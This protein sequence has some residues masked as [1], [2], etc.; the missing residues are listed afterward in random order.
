MQIEAYK[1]DREVCL[2]M[3]GTQTYLD[4]SSE[5]GEYENEESNILNALGL[6]IWL[7]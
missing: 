1:S 3:D 6:N 5:R 7:I 2:W 4:G